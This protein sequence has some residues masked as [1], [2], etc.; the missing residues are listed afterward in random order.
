MEVGEVVAK[1]LALEQIR[2]GAIPTGGSVNL[3]L[4]NYV[5]VCTTSDV[6]F[7]KLLTG[8]VF[9]QT[10]R[11]KSAVKLAAEVKV[12]S[13]SGQL[14]FEATDGTH[15]VNIDSAAFTNTATSEL[16]LS[17]D[18][19]TLTPNVRWTFSVY[20][21]AL[22]GGTLEVSRFLVYA[23]PQSQ[24]SGPTLINFSP[25]TQVNATSFSLLE[26][27]VFIAFSYLGDVTAALDV[28]VQVALDPGVTAAEIK[29]VVSAMDAVSVTSEESVVSFTASGVK[30]LRVN[31]PNLP[32]PNPKV[33]IYGRVVSGTGY[34]TLQHYEVIGVF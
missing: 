3:T 21:S 22:G 8:S 26:S 7:T 4:F 32:D 28:P 6:A 2:T 33:E 12:T 18:C 9:G 23:E 5:R 10:S 16:K 25:N 15:T 20:G 14:R 13:G 24:L 30:T 1:Q 34:I 27:S 19:S 11:F 17:L 29:V 31:Y